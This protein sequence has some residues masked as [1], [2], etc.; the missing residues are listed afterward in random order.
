MKSLIAI[1][2]LTSF[3]QSSFANHFGDLADAKMVEVPY[4]GEYEAKTM[5]LE[6]VFEMKFTKSGF[7]SDKVRAYD[8]IN[9]RRYQKAFVGETYKAGL[10]DTYD[11]WRYVTVY[12]VETEAERVS[13]LPYFEEDCHD[14]SQLMAQWDE[15][16]SFKVSLST[17]V[18]AEKLGLKASVT[19]SL[20]TGVTFSA[21]R[22][23]HA[24][25]GI[26]ARHYPYKLSDKWTGVTYIQV[27]W[28]DKNKYGYL[29]KLGGF[30]R[31]E[32]YPHPF[33]LDNQNV[34]FKVKREV[35]EKCDN[36]DPSADSTSKTALYL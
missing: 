29:T 21:A 22:R 10:F 23:V 31:F 20:E 26:R 36:Y 27:Y 9:K 3:T 4:A 12:N 35:L 32:E 24:T 19:M 30:D 28:A 5:P 16:R 6:E 17:T 34:G 14:A 8:P 13:Y 1:A 33:E 7:P 18:G 25:K 2:L 15:S 11:Y